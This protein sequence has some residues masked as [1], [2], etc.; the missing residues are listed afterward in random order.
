MSELPDHRESGLRA[1]CGIAAYYRI[2][3]SPQ[4]LQ[5][6]LGISPAIKM[7]DLVRAAKLIGLKARQIA[8]PKEKRLL[9]V[10]APAVVGLKAGGFAVYGGR[11]P[12]GLF[13][14]VD[15]LTNVDQALT[16]PELQ[17][18]AAGD[19]L[20]LARRFA[21][22]GSNPQTFGLQWFLPT[23]WRFRKPL[24][25]VLIA[26]LFIQIFALVTPL[27][28]QEVIDKVL[29][30]RS[31][32]TLMVLV[33][34]V[35][36]IGLF[37]TILQYLRTYALTHTTNRIDVELGQ[38]VFAHMMRL[39]L[40]YFE[41]RAAG[42]TVARV[43]ELENIRTF[44]TGQALFC[45]MDCVF[46]FVFF[47]VLFAYSPFL[48]MIVAATIPVYFLIGV[49][50]R[51]ALA[52]S[53]EE[54]FHRGA[55]SQQFL[56]ESVIGVHTI[57]AAAI[58][59]IVRAEW[60]EKLAAYVRTSFLAALMAAGGQNAI[61]YVSK[62]TTALL[63]LFGAR[64]V[65]D[66]DLSVGGLVAF[67]MI[68]AQVAQPILR[69]SQLA[70]DFQQVKVSIDRLADLLNA[71]P[72]PASPQR[73]SLPPARGDIK[74]DS[75]TFRYRP[76]TADVLSRLSMTVAAGEVIGI[77]GASGSGKSTLAKLIQRLYLPQEGQIFVDGTDI[78]NSD[79]AWL[80]SNVGVVLQ[81]N[82]L[83][84][85]T[86]R[87]NI[88]LA[89]PTLEPAQIQAVAKLAG[90]HEFIERMPQ[91][92]E[93]MIEERG[94][95]LS[96]GQ[97]QRIAIARTLAAN[98]RILILDEATSA[99]DYESERIIRENMR[100]IVK[101]RTVIVIAH[102]LTAVRECDRILAMKDGCIIE[103]GSHV[104]LLRKPDGLYRHLW[105]LQNGEEHP[106]DGAV[107][108]QIYPR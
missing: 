76:G 18:I 53:I 64:A 27:F 95:N 6:E 100:E 69:L 80:R 17:N 16:Y 61:Q 33:V 60:E 57:K 92:Y 29:S 73:S 40:S 39:P 108:A 2:A 1:V 19:V 52:K 42:Q 96:G 74:F 71:P 89:V 22:S 46:A 78:A 15:P 65:I 48:T 75:V 101:G 37:D 28:F 98:P 83:F 30:H 54:K 70:Q 85:R 99:L 59:P 10:P 9:T 93:T 90:A 45:A 58:E 14:L 77:V 7:L 49:L 81:E 62:L 103:S 88:A 12:N 91:G 13:R 82:L 23:I 26:S 104:E 87:E 86:I 67:N 68:S 3:A 107:V 21:G 94:A 24:V 47:V 5:R 55:K 102:R 43:R 72:E 35:A 97:R 41:T 36:G 63:M 51:P 25:H 44:L 50:I 66:G 106:N 4:F 32:S 11:L 79:L 84:N 56:I 38:R 31:Y 8:F 20:L 105:M 34:G